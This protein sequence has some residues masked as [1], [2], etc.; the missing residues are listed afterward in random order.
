MI[1][2]VV[3]IDFAALNGDGTARSN[4]R[5]QLHSVGEQL[6]PA[7]CWQSHLFVPRGREDEGE[8]VKI[9]WVV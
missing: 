7:R 1:S 9:G 3:E 6:L 5:A 2:P 4:L 8:G